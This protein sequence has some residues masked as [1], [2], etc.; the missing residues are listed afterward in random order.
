MKL[1]H[2]TSIS[3][4]Q[5]MKPVDHGIA[6]RDIYNNIVGTIGEFSLTQ[7]Y[8]NVPPLRKKYKEHSCALTSSNNPKDMWC[9]LI[10]KD[11]Q[12]E[13]VIW[14]ENFL[15]AETTAKHAKMCASP[16]TLKQF[17][18]PITRRCCTYI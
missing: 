11:H 5:T 15:S 16:C 9:E 17:H 7:S 3:A 4:F 2:G 13:E 1:F 8:T 12:N 18:F 14:M 10:L 6:R